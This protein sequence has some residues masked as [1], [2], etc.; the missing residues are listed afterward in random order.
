MKGFFILFC[1]DQLKGGFEN[2]LLLRKRRK[3]LRKGFCLGEWR[4]LGDVFLPGE[5]GWGRYEEFE[6]IRFHLF[7]MRSGVAEEE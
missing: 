7:L 2:K 4:I 1:I 3:R 6:K 5:M